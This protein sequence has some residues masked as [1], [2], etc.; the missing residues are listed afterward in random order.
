MVFPSAFSFR[1]F[2]HRATVNE[3]RAQTV[4]QRDVLRNR[5]RR[6]VCCGKER[7]GAAPKLVD[8]GV[9]VVLLAREGRLERCCERHDALVLVGDGVRAGETADR[10]LEGRSC[11]SFLLHLRAFDHRLERLERRRLVTREP[12]SAA[13]FGS[14]ESLREPPEIGIAAGDERRWSFDFVERLCR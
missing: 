5:A 7:R 2:L 12:D 10:N 1:L 4:E 13:D 3:R 14:I 11:H 9:V 6:V 8:D